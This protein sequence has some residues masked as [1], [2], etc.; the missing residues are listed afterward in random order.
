MKSHAS[1]GPYFK[2]GEA[3]QITGV[4]T[5]VLRYWETKFKTIRPIR[6]HSRHRLYRKSD[7]DA[8]M[9]IKRLLYKERLTIAGAKRRMSRPKNVMLDDLKEELKAIKALLDKTP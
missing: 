6:T 9:E 8:V 2:I 1:E 3:S 4:P 7:I 5:Y